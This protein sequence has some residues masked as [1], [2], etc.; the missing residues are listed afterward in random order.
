MA[1]EGTQ[2]AIHTAMEMILTTT[3][4]IEV[5]TNKATYRETFDTI[6]EAQLWLDE[7]Y[8]TL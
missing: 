4:T 7:L 8:S 6:E 2:G 3:I 1:T 5:E